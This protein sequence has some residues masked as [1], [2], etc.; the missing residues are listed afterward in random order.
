MNKLWVKILI[1]VLIVA[2]IAALWI[3]KNSPEEDPG[4]NNSNITETPS[5]TNNKEPVDNNKEPVKPDVL[6]DADFSLVA[7]NVNI[8]E[9]SKYG[10]P[11][12][13]DY[14]SE[15][16]MP[17]QEMK[18]ALK[19]INAKM[20]RKAFVKYIDVWEYP[21]SAEGLPFNLI[22]TQFFYNADGTPF[23]PSEELQKHILF[24]MYY[25]N[26]TNE[27]VFTT[28]TGGL[29]ENEFLMILKE[30]GVDIND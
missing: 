19:A 17:C 14:G 20:N 24:D 6:A 2:V 12:I 23:V 16:C 5:D 26:D 18:P 8:K 30:M 11:I 7:T 15:G 3:I 29:S 25:T 1:P 13:I 22:P 28:H 21:E 27:H 10:L 4:D 9:L